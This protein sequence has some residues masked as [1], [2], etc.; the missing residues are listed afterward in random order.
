VQVITAD[1]GPAGSRLTGWR[2]QAGEPSSVEKNEGGELGS[3]RAESD[4][5]MALGSARLRNCTTLTTTAISGHSGRPGA[6]A[7][8]RMPMLAVKILYATVPHA[9][10][11]F[12]PRALGQATAGRATRSGYCLT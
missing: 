1:G 12:T 7:N 5:R 2:L 6:V 4:F 8:D 3:S 9:H 10:H 11:A